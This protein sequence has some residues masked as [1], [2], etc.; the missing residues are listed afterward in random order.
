M[1]QIHHGESRK[2]VSKSSSLKSLLMR[3]W[4]ERWPA[5]TWG[6]RIKTVLPRGGSGDAYNLA[7]LL[8]STSLVSPVPNGLILSYLK[9]A[10]GSQLVSHL[11]VLEAIINTTIDPRKPSCHTALLHLL[12]ETLQN[13]IKG[14]GKNEECLSLATSL[15]SLSSWLLRLLAHSMESQQTLSNAQKTLS[16]LDSMILSRPFVL[17][18]FT[19]A[20][21]E[22]KE[23]YLK[24]IALCKS[25]ASKDHSTLKSEIVRVTAALRNGAEFLTQSE[26]I[27]PDSFILTSAIQP[28]LA[29]EAILHPNS[30]LNNLAQGLNTL[31]L[32]HQLNF[33]ELIYE[34][35]RCMILSL[36]VKEEGYELLTW[37]SFILVRFPSLLDRLH[38]LMLGGG[39]NFELKTPTD[40]YK[41]FDKLLKSESLCDAVD[42]RCKCSI[43]DVLLRVVAKSSTPLMTETEIEDV[44][45]KRPL[46]MNEPTSIQLQEMVNARNFEMMS[47]AEVTIDNILQTLDSDCT[48]PDSLENL[49]GVLCHIIKGESFDLLLAASSANGKL[50]LFIR[51]M[52]KLNQQSQESQGES[53]KNSCLRA[54]LF[55]I[56][57]LMLVHVVQTFG[58]EIVIKE[59]RGT[60][61]ESWI[62]EMLTEEERVKYF[63][64]TGDNMID[65]ILSQLSLGE[66][67]TQVVKWQ[68]VCVNIHL[69][70]KEMVIA[71]SLGDLSKESYQKMLKTMCGRLCALPV[72]VMS[73]FSSFEL[74]T[75]DG[76]ECDVRTLKNEFIEVALQSGLEETDE[77]GGLNDMPHAKERVA[78]MSIIFKKILRTQ[79]KKRIVRSNSSLKDSLQNVWE[80]VSRSGWLDIDSVLKI[81]ELYRIGGA[82]WL[83]ECLIDELLK[84]V[85]QEDMD[86]LTELVISIFHVDL[87][88]CTLSLLLHVVPGYLT[89]L[90][91][92]LRLTD[93]HGTLLAK[94][95]VTSIFAILMGSDKKSKRKD[96]SST[97]QSS[98]GSKNFYS[99]GDEFYSSAPKQRKID[100]D[101]SDT[102]D[103]ILGQA[104]TDFFKVLQTSVQD[105][106]T[107]TP[108][109][110]FAVRFL[111][112]AALRGRSR[113]ARL[114]FSRLNMNMITHLIKVV[115][116]LFTYSLIT[117]LF[118]ISST[119][120]RKNMARTLCFLKN[121]K[122]RNEIY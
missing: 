59:A 13:Y 36:S 93:P 122:T 33:S 109:M 39:S 63:S 104:V 35:L 68:N 8:L 89:S 41:A 57:F 70:M 86:R 98:S 7:E 79:E 16:L 50:R 27:A 47:K 82:Q 26:K 65:N 106:C 102:E 46:T 45:K 114:I 118:D 30:D 38:K 103:N 12:Q 115:P 20:K 105:T 110:H 28:V 61:I 29:F 101:D 112:Q 3:G 121:V 74:S 32:V 100:G 21:A 60:F 78:L 55:D 62:K 120:G 51:S 19:V 54:A 31:A 69:V 58:S 42:V 10:L 111:E 85:Y 73:W 108:R 91:K 67:R 40:L 5:T 1:T 72:C 56:T 52:A 48:K 95:T 92:S 113:A 44:R 9:H 116:D 97:P 34:V 71:R 37:D 76:S 80:K 23:N 43:I 83:S 90:E 11:S 75:P 77:P 84:V 6:I 117:K 17:S 22:D 25:L 96:G 4:R 94:V 53:V 14:S 66:L 2:M 88:Q 64:Q 107:I 24:M 81:K 99:Q 87:E 119:S 18:L 49:L 15:V